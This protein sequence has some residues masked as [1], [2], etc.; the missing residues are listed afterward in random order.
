M[1][2]VLATPLYP[3]D[4]AEPAP[5][6]K[7]LARRLA[8][9]GHAITVLTYGRLPE[10]ISG[11]RIIAVDNHRPLIIRLM[12]FTRAL[13]RALRDADIVYAQNGASVELPLVLV[14]FLVRKPCIIR[15]GDER[16]MGHATRNALLGMIH[17]LARSRARAII[18][19]TPMPRP[20]VLPFV[21]APIQA[22]QTYEASWGEHT[23]KLLDIFN[24][25]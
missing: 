2:I 4:I 11:V 23:K 16:A 19:D 22:Q 1:K 13:W 9:R 24:H 6:I 5:Y 7:E 8:E 12:S 3:P 20:E 18:T 10:R 17:R 25:A 15:I 21:P 14:S